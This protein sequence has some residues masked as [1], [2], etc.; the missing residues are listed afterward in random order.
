M[1][2]SQTFAGTTYEEVAQSVAKIQIN[3]G[4]ATAF[5]I[6]PRLML[7]N[8]HVISSETEGRQ[9]TVTFLN[10]DRY[11][12]LE[13]LRNSSVN[14]WAL[15]RVND[16]DWDQTA[17]PALAIDYAPQAS[18]VLYVIG[19]PSGGDLRVSRFSSA[20]Y[21]NDVSLNP[22]L[23]Q[24]TEGLGHIIGDQDGNLQAS[25]RYEVETVGG[26]SGSPVMTIVDGQH[27]VVAL[28]ANPGSGGWI[29]NIEPS[30]AFWLPPRS[31]GRIFFNEDVSR[32]EPN[33]SF[34]VSL[35]DSDLASNGSINIRL[36]SSAGDQEELTLTES[37]SQLGRFTG[38]ISLNTAATLSANNGS[39]E[40]ASMDWIEAEYPTNANLQ[41]GMFS[42]THAVPID[43][44][45]QDEWLFN[46]RGSAMT[47]VT[48]TYRPDPSLTQ[49][50]QATI[51]SGEPFWV[52]SASAETYRLGSIEEQHVQLTSTLPFYGTSISELFLSPRGRIW[53]NDTFIDISDHGRQGIALFG[54]TSS[55]RVRFEQLSDRI[56]V[57]W[58]ELFFSDNDDAGISSEYRLQLEWHTD[59]TIIKR[60]G[61]IP[62]NLVGT[63]GL[64]DG[65]G[66]GA[67][68][69]T[70]FSQLP[71]ETADA[72]VIIQQPANSTTFGNRGLFLTVLAQGT[73]TLAYQWYLDDMP[74]AGQTG[75]SYFD[76]A[77]VE[78]EYYVTVTDDVATTTSRTVTYQI[79]KQRQI[80]IH[81]SPADSIEWSPMPFHGRITT[82]ED[83][84][85]WAI[86][87]LFSTEDY[88]FVPT[89]PVNN[90]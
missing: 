16:T 3:R 88:S 90:G 56:V 22:L 14:D 18:Q 70:D 41:S 30:I 47:N 2:R 60:Y 28:H 46:R 78:G 66:E 79:A 86:M 25:C 51:S 58:D 54:R 49:R 73:G 19:H 34:D 84:G 32:I 64:I 89:T 77:A 53:T 57:T 20:P 44:R 27:R 83:I 17:H 31:V 62:T 35:L 39:I 68:T 15:L 55:G 71:R 10:G 12:D 85:T 45:A 33:N 38:T 76:F 65:A 8:R 59:G 40:A 1:S 80:T 21:D 63:I 75:S 48:L 13:L 4:V 42:T 52:H 43:R 50:Y 7:T 5:V 24:G 81:I 29:F 36:T 69:P 61:D 74:I 11:E 26:S 67:F 37:S 82:G 23:P 9:A 87:D 6:G 72:P